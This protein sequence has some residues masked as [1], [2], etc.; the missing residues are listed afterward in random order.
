LFLKKRDHETVHY[1]VFKDQIKIKSNLFFF[2]CQELF[3]QQ[4]KKT[5]I[6]LFFIL[7][8]KKINK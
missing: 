4:R 6:T 5:Y 8:K 3:S 7:V 1:L 2:D